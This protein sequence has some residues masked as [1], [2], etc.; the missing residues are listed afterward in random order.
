MAQSPHLPPRNRPREIGAQGRTRPGADARSAEIAG[1]SFP[2]NVVLARQPTRQRGVYWSGESRALRVRLAPRLHL[3]CAARG[4]NRRRLRRQA[5]ATSR[6][7]L[8]AAYVQRC[9]RFSQVSRCSRPSDAECPLGPSANPGSRQQSA[10][11]R[12]LKPP[13]AATVN[14][15]EKA[16]P[17]ID[18]GLGSKWPS[19]W[20]ANTP[21]NTPLD[22]AYFRAISGAES[23]ADSDGRRPPLRAL[24]PSPSPFRTHHPEHPRVSRSRPH[25]HETE[26]VS[27]KLWGTPEFERG[28]RGR[29]TLICRVLMR[30]GLE[31]E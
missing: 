27:G 4:M 3:G 1:W 24:A 14:R 20:P 30:K 7:H 5:R 13:R 18:C 28:G 19:N 31:M 23:G 8:R 6:G 10:L 15:L 2:A 9:S 29:R 22:R 21:G 26:G 17:A 25:N 12:T 11:C 16:A